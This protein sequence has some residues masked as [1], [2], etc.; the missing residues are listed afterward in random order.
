MG[1]PRHAPVPLRRPARFRG[2]H[3]AAPR[4]RDQPL[5]ARAAVLGLMRLR[6]Q[7]KAVPPESPTYVICPGCEAAVRELSDAPCPHCGRCYF[8]GRKGKPGQTHCVCGYADDADYVARLQR[9]CGISEGDLPRERRRLQIR[10]ELQSKRA[11]IGA[12]LGGVW[13][14]SLQPLRSWIGLEAITQWILFVAVGLTVFWGLW[15]TLDWFF[16]RLEERRLA[17]EFPPQPEGTFRN[18]SPPDS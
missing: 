1:V 16:R 8:C 2:A 4:R 12:I 7:E 10:K 11:I 6:R 14:G 18:P 13:V 3:P 15:W 17:V 5:R 9:E